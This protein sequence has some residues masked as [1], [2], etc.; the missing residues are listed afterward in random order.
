MKRFEGKVVLITGGSSGIGAACTKLFYNEGAKVVVADMS[1]DGADILQE[2]AISE[3]DGL[4]LQTDVTKAEEVKKMTADAVKTFG[5][6]DILVANA[7]MS[8]ND[9]ITELDPADWQAVVDVNLTGV[10]L[11]DKAAI[12]QMLEQEDRGTIVNCGSIHSVA[13]RESIPAYA[14]SKGGVKMLSQTLAA[15]YSKEGIRVNTVAPGYIETPLLGEMDDE[16]TQALVDLHPIG[17][18]GRPE[19]VA[20]AVAFLASDQ[21]SFVNGATLLVDGGYTAV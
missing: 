9:P 18:L 14:A 20:E 11:S 5:K 2:M 21:A 3:E 4:F 13:G 17:R 8:N 1:E 12:E 15:T 7:G 10:F 6:I 16:A 19:E